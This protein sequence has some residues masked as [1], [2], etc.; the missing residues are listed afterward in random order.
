MGDNVAD[1]PVKTEYP[2]SKLLFMTR[3]AIQAFEPLFS[4]LAD[5][6][7]IENFDYPWDLSLPDRPT[8]D[9]FRPLPLIDGMYRCMCPGEM[10]DTYLADAEDLLAFAKSWPVAELLESGLARLIRELL[11]LVE[12]SAL[13]GMNALADGLEYTFAELDDKD[14]SGRENGLYYYNQA[15]KHVTEGFGYYEAVHPQNFDAYMAKA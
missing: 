6:Y 3:P 1:T 12:W 5:D 13:S 11:L 4:R 9:G 10:D 7:E 2:R 15:T 8:I 14:R